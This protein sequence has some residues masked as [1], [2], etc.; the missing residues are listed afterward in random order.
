[1]VGALLLRVTLEQP[2]LVLQL[3]PQTLGMRPDMTLICPLQSPRAQVR[4]FPGRQ[5]LRAPLR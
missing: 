5:N 4:N 3:G 1:M 2:L